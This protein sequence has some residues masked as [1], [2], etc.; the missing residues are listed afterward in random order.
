MRAVTRN[1]LV[2]MRA[3]SGVV[4][5]YAEY[6]SLSVCV[7]VYLMSTRTQRQSGGGERGQSSLGV[8][9]V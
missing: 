6:S 8:D 2:H 4:F 9:A 7:C 3:Q 1:H 5:L